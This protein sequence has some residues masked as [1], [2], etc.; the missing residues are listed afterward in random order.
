MQLHLGSKTPK[1]SQKRIQSTY[2]RF[3]NSTKKNT[4]SMHFHT[5]SKDAHNHPFDAHLSRFLQRN[6]QESHHHHVQSSQTFS[7]PKLALEN[8]FHLNFS[9]NR[10]AENSP[11]SSQTPTD[12][13]TENT[14][15]PPSLAKP[16]HN[17]TPRATH[18]YTPHHTH[19]NAHTQRAIRNTRNTRNTHHYQSQCIQPLHFWPYPPTKQ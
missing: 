3:K 15:P 13:S 8:S 7:H 12:V 1:H 19:H 11:N 5:K 6:T 10:L 9:P 14:P 16:K 18:A 4:G 2:R 17:N